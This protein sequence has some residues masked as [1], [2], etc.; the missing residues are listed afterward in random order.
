MVPDLWRPW[1]DVRRLPASARNHRD[2]RFLEPSAEPLGGGAVVRDV[3][4]NVAVFLPVWLVASADVRGRR[5]YRHAYQANWAGPARRDRRPDRV[6]VGR[7]ALR[8]ARTRQ[9]SA[10]IRS[11][12]HGRFHSRRGVIRAI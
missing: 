11:L 12:R 7:I 1:A 2:V 4:Q 8:V 10:A 9:R 5:R 3:R 6:W